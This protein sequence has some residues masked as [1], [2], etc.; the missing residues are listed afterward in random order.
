MCSLGG[1]LIQRP[2]QL[3]AFELDGVDGI[4]GLENLLIRAETKR[5]QENGAEELALAVNADVEGVLLVVLELH[6]RTAVRDDLAQE[7]GTRIRRLEEDAGRAVQL[8]DDDTLGTVDDEGAVLSHQRNVA[9][10]DFLLLDVAHGLRAGLCIL[11]VDGEAHGDFERRRVGH[12]T[13]FALGLVVLQLQADGIAA[14][15][16]EVR[17]VFVISA[18]VV[19]EHIAGMKGIGDHHGA[20]VDAGGAQVMKSLQV[21]ALALPVADREVHEVELR[22]IAEVG[23]GKDRSKHRL[24]PVVLTLGGQLIHLQEALV[25]AALH[26]NQIRNLDGGW[27]LRKVEAAAKGAGFTGHASLLRGSLREARRSAAEPGSSSLEL[28]RRARSI[29]LPVA[30]MAGRLKTHDIGYCLRQRSR[31]RG[32]QTEHAGFPEAG[33]EPSGGGSSV[34]RD[35]PG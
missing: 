17:G 13:L 34:R 30:S 22:D 7:V 4:E 21:A 25:A 29:G 14:L 11:V 23:D 28:G 9:E 31:T 3:A 10:E 5:A 35:L 6:P 24:E 33:G 19:A 12:A 15:V 16:A 18:A 1:V 8:G 32:R 2:V 26:F 20:A 27:D